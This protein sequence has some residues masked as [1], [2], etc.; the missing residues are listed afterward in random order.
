MKM[1]KFL[2]VFLMSIIAFTEITKAI[3]ISN[4]YKQGIYNLSDIEE[5]NATAK[6]IT[7]NAVTVTS[8]IIVDSNGNPKFYK[9]FDAV[10]ESVNLTSIKSG[11]IIAIIGSGEIAITYS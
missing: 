7:S 11:D 3:P 2:I 10:N 6:L 9:R 8:L 4:T 1:R 5:F